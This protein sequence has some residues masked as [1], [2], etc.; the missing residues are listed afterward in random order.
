MIRARD[1]RLVSH[2]H[3]YNSRLAHN[4]NT[5][6]CPCVL[7]WWFFWTCDDEDETK[8]HR[9]AAVVLVPVHPMFMTLS[10]ILPRLETKSPAVPH[11]AEY[12]TQSG[13]DINFR[14]TRRWYYIMM[15]YGIN[16]GTSEHEDHTR[17]DQRAVGSSVTHYNASLFPGGRINCGFHWTFAEETKRTER[18]TGSSSPVWYHENT[19]G[20]LLEWSFRCRLSEME[21]SSPL[22]VGANFLACALTLFS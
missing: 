8:E 13:L 4:Q 2:L 17:D 15:S 16:G 6:L 9:T 1:R 12:Y 3:R 21:E 5:G 10:T 22:Y 11:E 18:E 19:T 20:F 7:S 14:H